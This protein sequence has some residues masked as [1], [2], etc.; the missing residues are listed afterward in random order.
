MKLV[1]LDRDGVINHDS[2]DFIKS[3]SEWIAIPGS[4]EAIGDLS[5]ND[6]HVIIITNQSGIGRKLLSIENLNRIHKR[7]IS[8]LSRYGGKIEAIFF[9]PHTPEDNCKCRKPKAGLFHQI[10]QHLKISLNDVP[11]ICDKLSDIEAAEE[12]GAKPILVRTGCGQLAI[13]SG[14]VPDHVQIYD[15]L[16]SA[17]A[18]ILEKD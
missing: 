1:L 10:S 13:D 9:C 16:A 14:D 5:Q 12:A 2:D 18:D 11:Y 6:Y 17:V 7:M 15:D 4:L 3:E 8:G